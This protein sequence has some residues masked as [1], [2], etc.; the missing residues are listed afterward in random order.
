MAKFTNIKV[1]ALL[2]GEDLP[3]Q[4]GHIIVITPGHFE[5]CFLKRDKN[6]LKNLKILVL[7]EADY[8]L[9]NDVTSKVCERSF[10]L[11]QIN[12]SKKRK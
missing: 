6:K 11:F 5:N 12:Y 8:M 7:D 1:Q 2:S 3:K 4:I 10:K 9:T